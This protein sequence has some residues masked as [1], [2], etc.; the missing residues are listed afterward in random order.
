LHRTSLLCTILKSLSCAYKWVH[1]HNVR[2]FPQAKLDSKIN[3]RVLLNKNGDLYFLLHCIA[4][5]FWCTNYLLKGKKLGK[6]LLRKE[7]SYCWKSA[8]NR[9]L[10]LED[11]NY[12]LE[13]ND[14]KNVLSECHL[15]S[16]DF[17]ITYILH[18]SRYPRCSAYQDFFK[19]CF[20]NLCFQLP[21]NV[22]WTDEI[23][24]VVRHKWGKIGPSYLLNKD[25]DLAFLFYFSKQHL[26]GNIQG[27]FQKICSVTFIS[28]E[29]P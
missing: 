11:A 28:E 3:A 1:G 10:V 7:N 8:Q 4:K 24:P 25:G 15:E 9:Y 2:D 5:L 23:K 12:D 20:S 14:L 21:Q 22:M 18:C 17:S 13:N 19:Y 27:K 16:C 29:S 6:K 26:V